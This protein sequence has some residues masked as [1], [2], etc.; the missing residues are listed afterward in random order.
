MKLLLAFGLLGLV[1]G[2]RWVLCFEFEEYRNGTELAFL[3]EGGVSVPNPLL[4]GLTLIPSAVAKGAVCLDGT[5]PGYHLHRGFGS[6]ENSWLI[7]LEGGGW[8]NDIK[9]CIYRKKTRRGS[10]N[11][12]EKQIPFTGLLSNKPDENPD[13]FSW[14]RVK[15]RYCDGASFSGEGYN[16]AAGL[17][18]RGQRIWLAAMEDLMSQGMNNAD[19]ALLSGCSAGGL[20]SILHCDEFRTLFPGN[21][22]IKCLADAGLFLDAIDVAGGHTMRTFFDGVVDLQ[23]VAKNLPSSCTSNMDA[24][25][26]FLPQ[27]L[28]AK[29]QTPLFLL[30]AA[31]DVWQLQGSL[32]TTRADP[33]GFWRQCKLNNANCNAAQIQ[34]LQGFRNEMLNALKEFSMS[35]ENGLFISSCFAHCQSE[36]QDTWFGSNSPAIADKGIANSVGDWYFDRSEVK[37]ID[38]PYP[39]DKTCHNIVSSSRN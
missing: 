24:T 28:V 2:R 8:C 12:M 22:K 18:F 38:C 39:C 35:K 19:K 25:T 5:A 9:T 11:Y 26:C 1:L 34:F 15:V 23:G 14:N 7:Q 13:F 6:G 32:A 33:H 4:V 30:N 29:V 27:N 16:E 3:E 37:E 21:T 17:F 36:R 20:A 31:Y 10:S